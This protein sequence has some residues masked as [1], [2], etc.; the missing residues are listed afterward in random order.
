MKTMKTMKTNIIGAIIFTG[1]ALLTASCGKKGC[2]DPLATNYNPDAIKYD[3]SCEY[4][5]SRT[6][7]VTTDTINGKEYKQIQGTIN[8]DFTMTNTSD[9]M[10]SGGVFVDAGVTLTIE[11]CT[12]IYAADDG[13]TPF[14]SVSQGGKLM[15]EGTA[16]CP[17][18]F[19]SIKSNPAPG[20]WGG[21]ILNGYANINTGTTAV[22]EGG[23]G[24]Y[25]GTDDA[26]NSGSLKYVRVEYA[27]KILG[28]DNEL[29]GFSFNGV[30]SGTTVEY[31]QAYRG[32]DDGMEFFG[33]TVSVKHAVSTGNQDDSFDWT[34]GWRGNGQ[35]WVAEQNTDAGDRG[36][37]ADNNGSDNTASP[38]SN[39]TLSNITLVGVDDG[40]AL[41]QGMK[42][43]EGTKGN[44]Y[45]AIVTGF[46]KRGIQV[47]HDVTLTNMDNNELIV[48]SVIVDNVNPFVYTT[49]N[50]T[51]GS[52]VNPFENDPTNSTG[53]V[54]LSGYIGTVTANAT[55]PT[56]LGSWFSSGN[57][58]GAVPSGNDW[59]SG[60]TKG[61]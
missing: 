45:N 33:G 37:E 11:E 31:I 60:W 25:G 46:P 32:A 10:L 13:T 56:T 39:P 19:T 57:Y 12:Q 55:N 8:E 61:L 43:R 2:T 58:I 38:F 49:S 51:P 53:T 35:F 15:A 24:I 30:G 50:A 18:V 59:T 17:I 4:N 1:C 36:I 28:T 20:D 5:N 52:P 48:K 9:W 42:L 7:F 22:G 21:I 6:F 47:E 54:S 34:H 26:D 44:I 27:G 16:N 14:L 40:D 3:G 23:T 41:N 29:N